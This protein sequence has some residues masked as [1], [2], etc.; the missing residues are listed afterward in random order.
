MKSGFLGGFYCFFV[1]G[2]LK[3]NGWFFL[4]RVFLQQPWLVVG[5]MQIDK[6]YA[7][8]SIMLAH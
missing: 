5:T 6:A 2:L 7:K 4:D 8:H 1:S 3:K